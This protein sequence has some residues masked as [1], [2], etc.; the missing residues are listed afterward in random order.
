MHLLRAL[1]FLP[2]RSRFDNSPITSDWGLSSWLSSRNRSFGVVGRLD[3]LRL[4]RLGRVHV[5]FRASARHGRAPARP[6]EPVEDPVWRESH[7]CCCTSTSPHR[8]MSPVVCF[9]YDRRGAPRVERITPS[10]HGA[11]PVGISLSTFP[12]PRFRRPPPSSASLR[13]FALLRVQV[14]SAR[15]LSSP[16]RPRWSRSTR[17]REAP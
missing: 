10:R 1:A 13:P 5:R 12:G 17:R 2:V 9:P 16:R 3:G 7:T 15:R 14:R 4:A 11:V 8:P 6:G